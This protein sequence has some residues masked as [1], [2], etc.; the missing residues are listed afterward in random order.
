MRRGVGGLAALVVIALIAGGCGGEGDASSG[1]A[2]LAWEGEPTL[3]AS[4][5]TRARVLIGTVKNTSLGRVR[6]RSSALTLVDQDGRRMK[7]SVGFVSTF[8]RSLYPQSGRPGARRS[9]FPEA[10]RRRIGDLAVLRSGETSPLTVSWN[11]PPG[12]R[13]ATRIDY[14]RGSLE[15]PD[16]LVK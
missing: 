1:D 2:R 3:R 14:G 13:D 15:I 11:E 10:E 5:T 6:I 16:K 12:R 9:E 7:A 4:E 8:V